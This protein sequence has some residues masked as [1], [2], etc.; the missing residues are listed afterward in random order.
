[1]YIDKVKQFRNAIIPLTRTLNWKGCYVCCCTIVR[2][3][4]VIIQDYTLHYS[5]FV[6]CVHC[7]TMVA[8]CDVL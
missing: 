1:M 2:P 7:T 3:S 8:H 5:V 4:V 6:Q